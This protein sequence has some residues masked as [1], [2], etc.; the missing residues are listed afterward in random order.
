VRWSTDDDPG[1]GGVSLWIVLIKAHGVT[2]QVGYV[3]QEH[4]YQFA[5]AGSAVRLARNLSTASLK[6]HLPGFGSIKLKLRARGRLFTAN[7][8]P[9]GCT[10]PDMLYRDETVTGRITFT[11]PGIGRVGRIRHAGR[12]RRNPTS[13]T[14]IHCKPPP[15]CTSSV[16]WE[17]VSGEA[18]ENTSQYDAAV[19][20]MAT[21]NAAGAPVTETLSLTRSYFD[22]WAYDILT[23]VGDSTIMGESDGT[24]TLDG[25]QEG[26][27]GTVSRTGTVRTVPISG[28]CQ[29]QI[30]LSSLIG[31]N[32]V[33]GSLAGT[34]DGVGPVSFSTDAS[35]SIGIF[36]N[37][38]DAP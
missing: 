28:R 11:I 26:I 21:R 7:P 37:R 25:A 10:A 27:S 35:T 31:P 36:W 16:G 2:G 33:N 20:V 14:T 30:N 4:E 9:P 8:A 29:G 1:G 3:T 15:T 34:F 32:S 18:I 38:Y 13:R 17:Q 12:A 22:R 6:A 23:V 19:D 24:V 5:L